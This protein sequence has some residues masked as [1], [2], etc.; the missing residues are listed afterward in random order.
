MRLLILGSTGGTGIEMVRQALERGHHVSVLARSPEKLNEFNGR[1]QIE[2]GDVLGPTMLEKAIRGS[3]A[4][5]SAFGPRLPLKHGEETLLRRFSAALTSA[6]AKAAVPRVILVST[7]FLFKDTIVPPAYLIGSLFFRKI[8]RDASE[9][10]AVIKGSTLDWT[11]VRP[12]KLTGAMRSGRY[13][14]R[15][16]HLPR[17]GFSI[18]R[19]DVAAFAI[20]AAERHLFSRKVVGVCR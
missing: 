3:D 1:I 7:A 12:P 19:A 2:T 18:S 8:V 6:M 20:E 4:V 13:R 17:F 5:L 11:I 16:E 10:E 9:M 14:F 15:Q